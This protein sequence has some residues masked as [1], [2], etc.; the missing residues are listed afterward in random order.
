[1][2]VCTRTGVSRPPPELPAV[3]PLTVEYVTCMTPLLAIPPLLNVLKFPVIVDRVTV[4]SPAFAMPPPLD[5]CPPVIFMS[6]SVEVPD[7]T[8]KT[9]VMPAPLMVRFDG[10]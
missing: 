3:L 4:R 9:L 1:M 7:A 8:L 6:A 2:P 10:P 5:E